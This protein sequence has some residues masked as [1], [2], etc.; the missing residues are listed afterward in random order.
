M[1][2]GEKKHHLL[3]GCMLERPDHVMTSGCS[4]LT[5]HRYL[6]LLLDKTVREA[7]TQHTQ[8]PAIASVQEAKH[9]MTD[10]SMQDAGWILHDT[11]KLDTP[12]KNVIQMPVEKICHTVTAADKRKTKSR[13]Y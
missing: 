6:C 2:R 5:R 3:V 1:Q 10:H 11:H 13:A 8:S 4:E 9:P 7:T 12:S